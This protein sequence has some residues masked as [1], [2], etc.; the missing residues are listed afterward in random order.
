MKGVAKIFSS[1]VDRITSAHLSPEEV[2]KALSEFYLEMV[3]LDVAVE[4]AEAIVDGLRKT[5]REIKVP[6]FSN[7]RQAVRE[8]VRATV[9]SLIKTADLAEVLRRAEEKKKTGKPVVMLFV[10]PNG[11]GKTTTVVKVA[12]YLR[13]KG[14]SAILASSDTFRAGAIEQLETLGEKAG[15]LVVSQQYG[16]DPAAVAVDALNKAISLKVNFVLIDTAGRTEVDR[17]LL[18][19][20][21][22]LKRVVKP[23]YVVY[24]GDALAGNAAVN[25]AKMFD[26]VV[27]IDYVILSKLDADAKGGSAISISHATGKPLLFVGV[28]QSLDDLDDK[29]RER[30]LKSLSLA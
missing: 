10:G 3:A 15:F 18:E 14:Y 20:M 21:R 13:K 4:T 9:E 5:T 26:E 16:A 7:H 17:G 8:H 11:S 1:V 29:P 28:G 27:G 23:D 22:K 2:E 6:R 30:L 24:T 19:E 25:Q 12:N